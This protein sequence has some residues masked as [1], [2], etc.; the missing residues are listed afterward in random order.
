MKQTK[1]A[2]TSQRRSQAETERGLSSVFSSLLPPSGSRL[3]CFF[4]FFA[5]S[6]T[7]DRP[8]ANSVPSLKPKRITTPHTFPQP[9]VAQFWLNRSTYVIV[10]DLRPSAVN[11]VLTQRE[12]SHIT[13]DAIGEIMIVFPVVHPSI[14]QRIV[15]FNGIDNNIGLDSTIS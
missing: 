15:T 4:F 7:Y 5:S 9:V 3:S 2:D 13:L 1:P 14:V 12:C 8:Q 6:V 10:S 11:G